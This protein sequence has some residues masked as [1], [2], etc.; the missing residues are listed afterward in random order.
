MTTSAGPVLQQLHDE[1]G[2]RVGFVSLYVREAHPG[3]RYPQPDSFEDKMGHARDYKDRRAVGWPVAVDDV[4]GSLHQALDPRPHAAYVMGADGSVAG[5]ALWANDGRA[6]RRLLDAAL[7]GERL[8]ITNHLV[9]MLRGTGCMYQVWGE[10]GGHAKT[11]VLQQVPPMYASGWLADRLAPLPP[12]ARG[13]VAMGT[14]LL[15]PALA[16]SWLLRRRA[17]GSRR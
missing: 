15:A 17:T 11:D 12:L 10:A 8:E 7:A 2:D 14:T 5:R 9:P 6:L 4:D 1:Y 13:A 16:A 3:D